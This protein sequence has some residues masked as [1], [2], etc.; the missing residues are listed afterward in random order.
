VFGLCDCL[1]EPRQCGEVTEDGEPNAIP[2]DS[3]SGPLPA[4][5]VSPADHRPCVAPVLPAPRVAHAL[6]SRRA[7]ARCCRGGASRYLT[8]RADGP[9]ILAVGFTSPLEIMRFWADARC[10]DA[11]RFAQVRARCAFLGLGLA[12]ARVT[13]NPAVPA[14]NARPEKAALRPGGAELRTPR[15]ALHRRPGGPP[16]AGVV[17]SARLASPRVR[18]LSM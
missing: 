4:S 18:L 7:A 8:H 16:D 11:L 15:G 14:R 1:Q 17:R 2:T 3:A 12:I 6:P 5:G 10:A 13:P 9:V